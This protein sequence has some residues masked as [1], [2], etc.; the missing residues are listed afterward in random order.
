LRF[1]GSRRPTDEHGARAG[2]HGR[3]VHGRNWIRHHSYLI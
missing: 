1:A 2:Q 3:G